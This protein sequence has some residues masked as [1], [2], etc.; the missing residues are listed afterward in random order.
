MNPYITDHCPECDGA[1]IKTVKWAVGSEI[2]CYACNGTGIIPNEQG[3]HI[4][5]L[6]NKYGDKH[7]VIK[8]FK[9]T[10]L[11]EKSKV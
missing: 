2:V 11:S 8:N 3:R 10:R 9:D 7:Y 4:V 5:E 1:G 6:L